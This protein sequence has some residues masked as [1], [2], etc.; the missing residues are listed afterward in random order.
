MPEFTVDLGGYADVNMGLAQ[1][2][3]QLDVIMEDLNNTL[4][5]IAQASNGKATPLWQEQQ[6]SWNRAYA[7]MKMQLNLHTN[8]SINV[9][10]TF[11]DGD[12]NGARAMA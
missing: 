5:H 12:N 10:Q 3:Q 7:E 1:Q 8:S 11:Q 9:A 2:V 6:S 4:N